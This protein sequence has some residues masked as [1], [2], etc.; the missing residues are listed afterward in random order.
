M[1]AEFAKSLGVADGDLAKM[2]AEVKANVEREVKKRI[3][4]E[5]KQKVMQAL[6]DSTPIE[7]PKS[8]VEMEM[9]RLVQ[10]ARADLEA[11]GVKMEQLPV[12]PEVFEAQASGAWPWD[13]SSARW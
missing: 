12:N 13:S 1:D 5:I 6:L 11:R 10:Q 4:G 3:D 2:R 9:Q 8:L 7:L